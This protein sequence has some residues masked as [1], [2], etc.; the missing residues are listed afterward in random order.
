MTRRNIYLPDDLWA[1]IQRAAADEGARKGHT[2]SASE[3]IRKAL[4]KE[5]EK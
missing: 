5:V 3:W 4:T 2:V 1:A